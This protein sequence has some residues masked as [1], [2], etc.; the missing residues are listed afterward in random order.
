MAIVHH[1]AAAL[2]LADAS[3]LCVFLGPPRQAV[4]AEWVQYGKQ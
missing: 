3:A 2:L 4:P 1:S